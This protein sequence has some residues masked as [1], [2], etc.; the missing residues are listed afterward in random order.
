MHIVHVSYGY[1]RGKNPDDLVRTHWT[2]HRLGASQARLAGTKVT[3]LQRFS[4]DASR[5]IDGVHYRFIR[6]S[7]DAP[8][9]RPW[10]RPQRLHRE[11]ARIAP[12]VLHVHG[13]VFPVQTLLLRRAMRGRAPTTWPARYPR[14]KRSCRGR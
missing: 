3:V 6:D 4:A 13:F 10:T 12:D 2:L 1:T 11:A 14:P 7:S 8:I 5:E 9:A